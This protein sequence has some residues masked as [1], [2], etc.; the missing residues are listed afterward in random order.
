[1]KSKNYIAT[2]VVVLTLL[3]PSSIYALDQG[4]FHQINDANNQK[5]DS[6]DRTREDYRF[7]L[8]FYMLSPAA[9]Y[10]HLS[11]NFVYRH[12]NNYFSIG[13]SGIIN[14]AGYLYRYGY[15]LYDLNKYFSIIPMVGFFHQQ[16]SKLDRE[17]PVWFL[18]SMIGIDYIDPRVGLN[19]NIGYSFSFNFEQVNFFPTL[20]LGWYF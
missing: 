17:Y 16:P 1:M 7:N 8:N 14:H 5:N 4:I 19:F 18:T 13:I 9:E 3:I 6:D 12:N 15:H 10:M 2:I 11:Q 20:A